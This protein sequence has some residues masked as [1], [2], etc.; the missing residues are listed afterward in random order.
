MLSTLNMDNTPL[1]ILVA[2]AVAVI[3]YRES[4]RLSAGGSV[5]LSSRDKRCCAEA[6]N[7]GLRCIGYSCT[8]GCENDAEAVHA[9]IVYC[10]DVGERAVI[11]ASLVAVGIVG[12][13]VNHHKPSDHTA[14]MMM[15]RTNELFASKFSLTDERLHDSRMD[16]MKQDKRAQFIAETAAQYGFQS[17]HLARVGELGDAL[18][19][20][21]MYAPTAENRR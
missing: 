21:A 12:H 15:Q 9:A 20:I 4:R 10:E 1:F 13:Y 7:E 19:G 8:P 14:M 5:A 3:A 2:I 17:C 16:L 6:C 11:A 18:R